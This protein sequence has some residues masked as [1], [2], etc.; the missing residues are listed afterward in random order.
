MAV[1]LKMSDDFVLP[2]R[3]NRN[4]LPAHSAIELAQLICSVSGPGDEKLSQLPNSVSLLHLEGTSRAHPPTR[5][6]RISVLSTGICRVTYTRLLQLSHGRPLTEFA[7]HLIKLCK[8]IANHETTELRSHTEQ[9]RS[10]NWSSTDPGADS[11]PLQLQ[12]G[13]ETPADALSPESLTMKDLQSTDLKQEN[14]DLNMEQTRSKTRR[15]LI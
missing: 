2:V 3:T 11:S 7:Q 8:Q 6:L 13:R 4:I 5:L 9:F 14:M 1:S 12:N 10:T 15:L